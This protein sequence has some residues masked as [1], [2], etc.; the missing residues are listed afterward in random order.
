VPGQFRDHGHGPRRDHP[1][2]QRQHASQHL[3][4]QSGHDIAPSRKT[5]VT[6]HPDQRDRRSLPLPFGRGVDLIQGFFTD[7]GFFINP[8]GSS[9][10]L[11]LIRG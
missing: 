1:E 7:H 8:G 2:D 5:T 6:T 4:Q 9:G 3:D 10:F 11:C